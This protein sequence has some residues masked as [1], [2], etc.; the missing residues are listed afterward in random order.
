MAAHQKHALWLRPFGDTAFELK[1][2][3]K[4]LSSEFETPVFDPHITLLKG[5]RGSETELIQLTDTLAAS[6]SPFMVEL[7]ELGYRDHYYQS[8]FYRVKR[9]H[10][11]ITVQDIAERLFGFNRDEEY[12]PHLSLMYGNIEGHKKRALIST[13]DQSVNITFPVHSLLLIKTN[14]GVQEWEKIHTAEFNHG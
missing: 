2:R 10:E 5:L 6:L 7:T 12:F 1:Q 9:T 13:M 11:L 4:R 3:I 8:L 14:G